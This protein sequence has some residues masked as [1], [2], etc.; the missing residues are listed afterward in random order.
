MATAPRFLRR[1]ILRSYLPRLIEQ[2]SKKR[3]LR[4]TSTSPGTLTKAYHRLARIE[5]EWDR[6][7]EAAIKTQGR[8]SMDD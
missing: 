5:K 2:E 4:V 1:R 3:I 8:P 7:E 6:I